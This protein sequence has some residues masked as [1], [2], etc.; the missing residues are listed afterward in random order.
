MIDTAQKTLET[1]TARNKA[2]LNTAIDLEAARVNLLQAQA[3]L[4]TALA[5]QVTAVDQLQNAIG[6]LNLV[7]GAP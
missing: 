1:A 3:S 6:S 7:A 2:G 4:E 5:A